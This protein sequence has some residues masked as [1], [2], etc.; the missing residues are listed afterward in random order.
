MITAVET[1]PASEAEWRLARCRTMLR[2]A[3]RAA[4]QRHEPLP[5][6]VLVASKI[7]IYYYTGTLATGLLWIPL[8]GEP[9][10]M[11]RKGIE[12]A[13]AESPLRHVVAFRSFKDVKPLC[14]EAGSPLG[15]VVAVE[16]GG[17]SWATANMLQ[18][19]LQNTHFVP[20][21][22]LTAHCRMVKSAWELDKLRLCGARHNACLRELLPQRIHPGMTERAIGLAIWDVF[23]AH[24]HGGLIRLNNQGDET[25]LGVVSAGPS[26]LYPTGFDGPLG[27]RGMHPA[28]PYMG[29]AGT[30]WKNGEILSLDVGFTLEGYNTDTTQI[31]WAGA[32]AIPDEI[33]RAQELCARVQNTAS[34]ALVPGACPE[35]IW[36]DALRQ[37]ADSPFAEQFMGIG[38][39]KVSFLGHG[40]GLHVAEQPVIAARFVQPLEENMVIALEPK[41]SLPGVGMVGVENTF[42]VTPAGGVSLTGTTADILRIPN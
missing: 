11:I 8:E 34:A 17:M 13:R 15:Q 9:V 5:C 27:G 36:R 21:D 39:D 20:G 40:I 4:E 22:E 35:D 33:V 1:L 42:V 23:L 6:G 7:N 29:D 38:P 28:L 10:L 14:A 18:E 2:R 31:Y 41:I 12:R 25:F 24:G 19:R 32:S 37:V 16:M 3:L 26:G 30:V